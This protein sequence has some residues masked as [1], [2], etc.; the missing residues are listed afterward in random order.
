MIISRKYKKDEYTTCLVGGVT[1]ITPDK[2]RELYPDTVEG[3]GLFKTLDESRMKEF[4]LQYMLVYRKRSVVAIAPCFMVNY[5]LDTSIN[6]PLRTFTN[7]IKKYLPRLFNVKAF[8][9]GIPAGESRIGLAG[10]PEKIIRVIVRRMEQ[11]A[12]KKRAPVVAFKDFGSTYTA[13]LSGLRKCGFSR[14]N[15]L[16]ATKLDVRFSD[17]DGYLK[18]LSHKTRYDLRRK[19]RKVDGCVKIDLEIVTNPE[20]K[21]YH[22]I[23]RLYRAVVD[24][25][26]FGFEVL[27]IEFFKNIS[28][29]MP[30]YVK[31]FLWRIDGKIV[32]FSLCLVSNDLLMG[33][34]MGL[35]YSVAY[36]HNLYFIK[37][38]DILNWCINNNIK[39]YDLGYTGYETKRR[40]GF[41]IVPLYL[42]VKL[43]NR[44]LRPIFNLLCQFLKFENFDAG[45][46]NILQKDIKI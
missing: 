2:W 17:F 36:K 1:S 11:V 25:H 18:T 10:D 32:A 24:K 27:L 34:C 33:Y 19:F 21:N 30:G 22:E 31:Y 15:S 8:V 44:S 9:C 20:E 38:R 4:E 28:K 45:L 35:D 23:Y 41:E 7:R 37:F 40:L 42:Y 5:A 3:Y 14:F 29:N 46:K 26:E 39:R 13:L 43:Q 12:R 16:P 6:G